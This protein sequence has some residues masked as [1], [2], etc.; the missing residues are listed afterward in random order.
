MAATAILPEE[1]AFTPLAHYIFLIPL[2][3]AIIKTVK[4]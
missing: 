4:P 1:S 2:M 3:G